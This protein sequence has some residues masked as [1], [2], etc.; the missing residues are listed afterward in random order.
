M[1]RTPNDRRVLW[2]RR[3]DWI[4]VFGLTGVTALVLL[5]TFF[6]PHPE[7]FLRDRYAIL[8]ILLV[9]VVASWRGTRAGV[10]FALGAFLLFLVVALGKGDFARDSLD[11]FVDLLLFLGVALAQGVQTGHLRQREMVAALNQRRMSLLS[12][13]SERLVPAASPA[14]LHECL[15]ELRDMMNATRASLFL[16]DTEGELVAQVPGDVVWFTERPGA[17]ALVN[18]VFARCAG[19]GGAGPCRPQ[20]G[21]AMDQQG[22]GGVAAPLIASGDP[23]GILYVSEPRSGRYSAVELDFLGIAAE[24]IAT[25]LEGEQVQTA[26]SAAAAAEAVSRLKSNLVS[27]VSHGLKTPL[28]AA[29]ATVTGLLEKE[30][31]CDENTRRELSSASEDLRVLDERIGDLMDLSR[32]EAAGWQPNLDWNDPADICSSVLS[33]VP[34]ASRSR[35]RCHFGSGLPIARFDLVHVTRALYHLVENALAYSPPDTPIVLT[36][37]SD[38]RLMRFSVKDSGPGI[39]EEE[40]EFIFDKFRRGS[41]GALAQGGTGLGLTIASEIV[42]YHGGRILIED[43]Q[44]HGSCFVIELPRE[45]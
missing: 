45:S 2:P 7:S 24:M 15:A 43:V 36:A 9:S 10:G 22:G 4:L 28:A 12:Q 40:R 27:S 16:A 21:D 6:A 31:T 23:V 33:L 44:P 32:L 38:A 3:P 37:S 41:A 26:M 18:R 19:G 25:Y 8:G 39:P 30:G 35:V 17:M 29:V 11:L 13:L 34:A 1:E 20:L 14:A 42:R 5:S